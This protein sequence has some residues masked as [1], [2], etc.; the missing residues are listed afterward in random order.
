MLS[1]GPYDI[2]QDIDEI[3]LREEISDLLEVE[4]LTA[5]TQA[6]VVPVYG[7]LYG[8]CRHPI[9]CLPTQ[10]HNSTSCVNIFY[11]VD[12]G[13]HDCVLSPVAFSALGASTTTEAERPPCAKRM[14][15]NGVH[16]N[17][18]LCAEGGIP[19]LG[20]DFL[21]LIGATVIVDYRLSTVSICRSA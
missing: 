9:V 2:M 4:Y 5:A 21:T 16:C 3:K 17:V 6:V 13:S 18:R 20:T 1:S 8:P 7:V 15:I 14:I 10:M 19:K 12:T 11:M